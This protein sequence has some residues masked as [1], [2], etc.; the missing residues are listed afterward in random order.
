[1]GGIATGAALLVHDGSL[2]AG[3]RFA[4]AGKVRG[5]KVRL[6]EGDRI[7]FARAVLDARPALI[8]GVSRHADALLIEEVARE[9]GYA[10][11]ALIHGQAGS[12]TREKCVS[13]WSGLGR[14]AMAADWHWIEA[15]ADYAAKPGRAAGEI[16]DAAT[17]APY[18]KGLVLGWML[19]PR[20]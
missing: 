4:A 14:L 8:A 15:L 13:G 6:I 3:R 11:V 12:C 2:E 1:V 9:A 10:R 17:S 19:A 5:A 16:A 20:G 7:R 18:D